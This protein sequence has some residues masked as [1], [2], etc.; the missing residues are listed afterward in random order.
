MAAFRFGF[1]LGQDTSSHSQ[2]RKNAD[3]V[4]VPVTPG[5]TLNTTMTSSGVDLLQAV[6]KLH[7]AVEN[8]DM[9]LRHTKA[10]AYITVETTPNNPFVVAGKLGAQEHFEI[11]TAAKQAGTPAHERKAIGG[12]PLYVAFKW[13]EILGGNYA[14]KDGIACTTEPV[15]TQLGTIFNEAKNAHYMGKVF[16]HSQCWVTK[17]NKKAYIKF[18]FQSWLRETEYFFLCTLLSLPDRKLEGQPA[19]SGPKMF[20]LRNTMEPGKGKGRGH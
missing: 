16:S 19:P 13:L 6:T 17:D 15:T 9:R 18:R 12:A 20:E 10:T 8:I 2:K 3:G 1:G 5:T 7:E 14:S 4:S 11:C